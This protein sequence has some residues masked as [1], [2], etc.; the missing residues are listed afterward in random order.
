MKKFLLLLMCVSMLCACGGEQ[1]SQEQPQEE[2]KSIP[3][4]SVVLKGKHANLFMVS[5]DSCKINLVKVGEDW[6]VRVKMTIAN[7]KSFNQL[8]DKSK[9]ERELSSI[10][11][12]LLNSSD[13]ELAS[14]DISTEDW[15]MLVA[16]EVDAQQ[17]MMMKTYDYEHRSYANAKDIYDKVTGIVLNNIELK[18]AEKKSKPSQSLFDDDA[19]QA[20]EE[21]QDILEM[22]GEMLNALQGL[23]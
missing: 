3:A 1:Q 21:V 11:G 22:E 13:V 2:S 15:D 8:S 9:Y 16:E 17:D 6:Q 19:K 10:Y 14:L 20:V 5:G 23:L 12:K 4:S 7:K 18:G